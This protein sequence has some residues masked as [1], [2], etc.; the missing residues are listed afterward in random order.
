MK[1][2]S[3]KIFVFIS[4]LVTSSLFPLFVFREF[5]ERRKVEQ[6]QKE[7]EELESYEAHRKIIKDFQDA[8][9]Y[10]PLSFVPQPKEKTVSEEELASLVKNYK[11]NSTKLIKIFDQDLAQLAKEPNQSL[12]RRLNNGS[13][14]NKVKYFTYAG[15]VALDQILILKQQ[16]KPQREDFFLLAKRE[17][18]TILFV[19]SPSALR[20]FTLKVE[21]LAEK[22]SFYF[23]IEHPFFRDNL[24]SGLQIFGDLPIEG[25]DSSDGDIYFRFSNPDKSEEVSLRI[26]RGSLPSFI[27]F[28]K[29]AFTASEE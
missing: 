15:F 20:E 16:I 17:K 13:T 22:P 24:G 23:F 11:D 4:V 26:F 3:K 2:T 5:H 27:E 29:S 6:R 8:G 21:K 18:T 1:L 10:N 28:L 25:Y 12:F 7:Q 9:G 19:L 14:I